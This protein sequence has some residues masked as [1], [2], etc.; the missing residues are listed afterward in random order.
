M[1]AMS[2]PWLWEEKTEMIKHI[3]FNLLFYGG[4]NAGQPSAVELIPENYILEKVVAITDYEWVLV[5]RKE[6]G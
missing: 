3:P 4:S 1:E 5:V 6:E 2:R